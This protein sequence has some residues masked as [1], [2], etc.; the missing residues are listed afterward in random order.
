MHNYA[1]QNRE[2]RLYSKAARQWF[3][4]TREQYEE[5]DRERTAFRKRMQDRGCCNCPRNKW[6]LC[7]MICDDCDYRICSTL[8][9]DKPEGDGSVCMADIIPDNGP[10]M[11]EVQADRDLLNRLIDRLHELD[12]DADILLEQWREN[13][14]VSDRAIARALGYPQRTFADKMKRIR[15]EM[16]KIRD[17]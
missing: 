1:N 17:D 14:K 10:L 16:R 6:W 7:D 12:P 11:E 4:V 2:Y 9:L 5:Y 8:S 15:T 3:P 13:D